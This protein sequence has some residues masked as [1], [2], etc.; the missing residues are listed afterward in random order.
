L[1]S[2]RRPHQTNAGLRVLFP[3]WATPAA[4][5][6]IALNILRVA[7]MLMEMFHAPLRMEDIR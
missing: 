1:N 6:A 4:E 7:N 2:G 3:R 5:N